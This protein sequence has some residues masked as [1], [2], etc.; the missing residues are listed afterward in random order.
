[1]LAAIGPD[2]FANLMAPLGPFE[3]A[4]RLAAA[5][6]GGADSLALAVLAAPWARARGGSLLALVVD[7]GLRRDS[8]A[9]AVLTIDRLATLGVPARLLPLTDLVPGP[10]LAARARA[11]RYAALAAACAAAGIVH[12]LVGHHAADQAETLLMRRQ[13]QSG[14]TGLAAMPSI[15]EQ[16][17]LRLLRPLLPVPP[18]RLRATLCMVG[19]G[20]VNDPSNRDQRALRSRLRSTLNDPDGIGL[21]TSALCQAARAAGSARAAQEA[22]IAAVLAAR[23]VIRPE[24]F[25][26]LSSGPIDPAALAALIQTI[27]GAPYPPPTQAVAALAAM[28]RPATLAGVRLLSAGRLG[29]GQLPI[30][31]P[32]AGLLLVREAAAMAPPVA[33]QPGATWDGRFRLARHATP[34]PETTIGALGADAARLRRHS[35][36]PAAVLHAVPALRRGNC[37]VAVPHLLYPDADTCAAVTL[38]F[39]PR[40]PAAGAPFAPRGNSQPPGRRGAATCADRWGCGRGTDTLCVLWFRASDAPDAQDPRRRRTRV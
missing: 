23:A 13:S 36:L 19:L 39:S 30:G 3:P 6:S 22:A 9:E 10:A 28:P 29:E 32:G 14:P 20:W 15:S 18:V 26:L 27:A 38:T 8:A 21:E 12:L 17:G 35:P 33:A 40:R 37:L 25:A 16:Y 11:E 31:D 1:M 7:H 24:G 4:P 5:V 34:L 2:E